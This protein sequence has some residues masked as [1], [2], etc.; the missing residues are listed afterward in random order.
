MKRTEMGKYLK[1]TLIIALLASIVFFFIVIP[2]AA[3]K[4]TSY[5]VIYDLI[6]VPALIFMWI[7]TIPVFISFYKF[8]IVFTEIGRDN[9][10]C[11]KNAR[12]L[13]DVGIF[14]ILDAILYLIA[15]IAMII[16]N[17]FSAVILIITL[18]VI[19]VALVMAVLCIALSHL[20][21]KAAAL[22]SENDL[23]I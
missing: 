16:L 12:A 9:S 11:E 18:F 14:A 6:Y 17:I 19:F 3:F 4:L 21:E 23:T 1:L 10:F 2:T 5:D 20:V 8:W 13:H 22:K 7:S 15:L